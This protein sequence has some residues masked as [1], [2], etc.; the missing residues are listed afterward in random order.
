[1]RGDQACT[2]FVQRPWMKESGAA[3]PEDHHG[4]GLQGIV[5]GALTGAI[6]ISI[7]YPTEFIKIHMQ[8]DR[9]KGKAREYAGITDVFKKTVKKHG[10]LGLYR[11]LSVMIIAAVPKAAVRFGTFET[12]KENALDSK[13]NLSPIKRMLCGLGAGV[14]EAVVVVTPMETIKTKFI[15]DQWSPSPKYK[16]FIRGTTQ[17]IK[18]DGFR[19]IYKGLIPTVMR[20]GSNQ[21]I[22]FFVVESL[23]NYYKNREGSHVVPKYLT[24]FF[25]SWEALSPS[26]VTRPLM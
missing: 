25:G 5:A 26:S 17:I 18:H 12:L 1:M 3:R 10:F 8:L 22:R 7:T 15:N 21:A 16:G 14:M 23:K 20:Q 4:K 9:A 6:E 19:G 2:A 13:G 24:A 11:G